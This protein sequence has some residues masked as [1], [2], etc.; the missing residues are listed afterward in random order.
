M[1]SFA[2][3]M[4]LAMG[5]LGCGD[6][7]NGNS[8]SVSSNYQYAFEQ[9]GCRTETHSFASKDAMCTG[10]QDETLNQGCAESMRREYFEAQDCAG[11]FEVKS[12][13]TETPN[14]SESS[15]SKST[16][17]YALEEN[18][19][20]TGTQEFASHQE[21]CDGLRNDELNDDCAANLRR[22]MFESNECAGEF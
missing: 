5:V 9:N 18:G 4:V 20:A 16:Y 7:G 11:T 15:E 14:D 17:R 21:L 13:E 22:E 12:A 10:L 6:G 19:C 1:K 2:I 8:K 3:G